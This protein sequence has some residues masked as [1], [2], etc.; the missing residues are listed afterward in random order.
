MSIS[1]LAKSPTPHTGS[2]ESDRVRDIVSAGPALGSTCWRAH[3]AVCRVGCPN[4]CAGE[5]VQDACNADT[6]VSCQIYDVV[7]WLAELGAKVAG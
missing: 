4:Q 3:S 7:S 6:A 2:V 5:P 1:T